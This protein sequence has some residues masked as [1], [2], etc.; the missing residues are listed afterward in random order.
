MRFENTLKISSSHEHAE[1]EHQFP[2]LDL[3]SHQRFPHS[4][5]KYQFNLI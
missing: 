3:N 2:K 5:K 1:N 4:A